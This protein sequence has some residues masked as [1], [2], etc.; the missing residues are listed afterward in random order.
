MLQLDAVQTVALAG[1]ALFAGYGLCRAIPPLARYNMPPPVIGGLV[2]ALAAWVA[3]ARGA[4]WLQLDTSLQSPLMV[5]FFTA[6]GFN[7]SMRLLRASGRQVIVLLALASVLALLQGLLGAA[8]AVG[9]GLHPLF[10]VLAGPTTLAGGPATGLAFAPLFE[11][12]GLAGAPSIALA[13]AM[14]G[15]LIGGLLGGPLATLLMRRGLAPS[16]TPPADG[17]RGATAAG[18]AVPS[19]L[20][21][22]HAALKSIVAIL[23]AMWIGGGVS[24]LLASSGVTLPAYVGAMLVGA[25]LRDLDDRFGWFGMS[26]ASTDVI[27]NICLAL[28]LSVALMN[29]KLWELSGLALPLVANLALQALLAA[30]FC[31]WVLRAMGRDHDAAVT[32]GGFYGFMMG[33]TANAMAVMRTLVE[34]HGPAPRA[35][36]VAPIVGAFFIDFSNA[37]II[38]G[39]LNLWG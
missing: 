21:R 12:A 2:F 8:V 32:A 24:G 18:E 37:L 19:P 31:L 22:E 3:H 9:F 5:A 29:L 38:T 36:L 33:T 4:A 15:I 30:A 7:A 13:A 6:I 11:Q 27:G 26:Q 23:L 35:F 16:I 1:V 25:A 28:F 17:A 39:F 34:R 20:Q 14:A 10:G